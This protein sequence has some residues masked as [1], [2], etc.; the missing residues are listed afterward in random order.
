M[1]THRYPPTAL[2]ADYFRGGCGLA[3]TGLPLLML[4]MHVVVAALFGAAALLF[5]TFLAGTVKRHLTVIEADAEGII[6]QGPAGTAIRWADLSTMR[7]NYY[8][9]RRDKENGWM[10]L[11]LKGKGHRMTLESSL[12]EFESVVEQAHR[13]ADDNGVDLSPATLENLMVLGILRP[14]TS[15]SQR[16]G[17]DV[18][19]E[20]E[21][22]ADGKEAGR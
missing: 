8:S 7:L 4:P 21:A 19:A 6:S 5:G 17:A 13:A 14:T 20:T 3:M 18:D 15:L 16:W 12:T 22:G 9:T 10:T 2:R 1:N 11:V